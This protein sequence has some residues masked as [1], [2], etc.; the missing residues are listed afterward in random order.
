VKKFLSVEETAIELGVSTATLYRALHAGQF[1]AVRIRGRYIVPAKVLDDM[2][3]AAL[4]LNG[5]VDVEEWA[6][7]RRTKGEG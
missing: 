2:A 5:I 1:P 4:R 7:V 3:E 6:V